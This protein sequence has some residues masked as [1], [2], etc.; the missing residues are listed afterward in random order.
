MKTRTGFVSNSSSSSFVIVV[1]K[2]DVDAVLKTLTPYEKK[3]V[4]YIK[5]TKKFLG[6]DVCVFAGSIGNC[7][8]WQDFGDEPTETEDEWYGSYEA[9]NTFVDKLKKQTKEVLESEMDF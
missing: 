5:K 1:P 4:N 8:S 7:D 6:T 3:V 9:W 2:A